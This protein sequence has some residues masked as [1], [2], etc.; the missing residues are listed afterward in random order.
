MGVYKP[1]RGTDGRELRNPD[2]SLTMQPQRRDPT[3][4]EVREVL[5]RQQMATT[6]AQMQRS[7]ESRPYFTPPAP[8][9]P[10]PPTAEQIAASQTP[11][12]Q[13]PPHLPPA[14][15]AGLEAM[16]PPAGPM[17]VEVF[18]SNTS[19]SEAEI[20][21]AFEKGKVPNPVKPPLPRPTP[22]DL[23]AAREGAVPIPRPPAGKPDE[24]VQPLDAVGVEVG[25][26]PV[27]GHA[28]STVTKPKKKASPQ[29]N[30]P[31]RQCGWEGCDKGPGGL[32]KVFKPYRKYEK[33]CCDD[34][35][36]LARKKKARDKYHAKKKA[37]AEKAE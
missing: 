36:E 34:C 31:A 27:R 2:G 20:A 17:V 1:A 18:E 22:E 16:A 21:E 8:P 6:Q 9:V 19:L 25:D 26:K 7:G 24:S 3:T 12:P 30:I 35:R 29:K 15:Q 4:A 32:A 14:V 10:P 33:F 28:K 11:L 5:R 23:A 13:A 37:A